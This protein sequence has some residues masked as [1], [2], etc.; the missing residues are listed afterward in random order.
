MP[1]VR[2]PSDAF[3]VSLF[4]RDGWTTLRGVVW[5]WG[6]TLMR[7]IP[8]QKGPMV[9]W[10]HVEAMPGAQLGRDRAVEVGRAV[11]GHQRGRFGR[12]TRWRQPSTG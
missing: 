8:G 1:A 4:E 3:V 7:D 6:D 2:V 11:C 12:E 9:D 10:P 5:D